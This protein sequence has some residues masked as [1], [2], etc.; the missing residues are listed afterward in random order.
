MYMYCSIENRDTGIVPMSSH[1][2]LN[3][4]N[5]QR[6]LRLIALNSCMS[7]PVSVQPKQR[8]EGVGGDW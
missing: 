7:L 5:Y 1:D 6:T 8:V 4:N 2:E 3:Y